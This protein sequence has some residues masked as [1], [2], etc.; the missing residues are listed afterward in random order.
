MCSGTS[1]E[2][3]RLF[4]PPGVAGFAKPTS[5]WHRHHLPGYMIPPPSRGELRK[6]DELRPSIGYSSLNAEQQRS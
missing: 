1:D 4:T 6:L 5:G 3:P 2:A